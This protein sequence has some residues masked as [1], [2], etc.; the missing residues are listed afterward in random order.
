MTQIHLAVDHPVNKK[1]S[2]EGYSLVLSACDQAIPENQITAH[3]DSVN[4]PECRVRLQRR[5][6]QE[7]GGGDLSPALDL[8][9][10]VP[11]PSELRPLTDCDVITQADRDFFEALLPQLPSRVSGAL[12]SILTRCAFGILPQVVEAPAPPPPPQLPECWDWLGNHEEGIAARTDGA[13]VTVDSIKL[14]SSPSAVPQPATHVEVLDEVLA[15]I[16]LVNALAPY[17]AAAEEIVAEEPVAVEEPVVTKGQPQNNLA[18]IIEAHNRRNEPVV[19]LDPQP[20]VWMSKSGTTRT[21]IKREGGKV[22]F[23]SALGVE[24]EVLESSFRGWIK[25]SKAAQQTP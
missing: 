13:Q 22:L 21:V 11:F 12:L 25:R 9:E 6:P 3:P 24:T 23:V 18:E 20:E 19:D 17:V 1:L 16:G 4:C 14:P 2:D 15:K 5:L 8:A 7:N 10:A